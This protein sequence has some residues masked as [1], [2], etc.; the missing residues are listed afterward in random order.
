[1]L[2]FD[3]ETVEG[4]FVTV[5]VCPPARCLNH[6]SSG[7][8]QRVSLQR[9]PERAATVISSPVGLVPLKRASVDQSDQLPACRLTGDYPET[10]FGEINE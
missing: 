7:P 6:V 2:S 8:P 4:V 1:M 10:G 3:V 5:I 9:D